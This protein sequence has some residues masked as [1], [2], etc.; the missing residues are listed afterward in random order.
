VIQQALQRQEM[1]KARQPTMSRR[2]PL[3]NLPC[4]SINLAACNLTYTRLL[5]GKRCTRHNVGSGV[6]NPLTG[7]TCANKSTVDRARP[8]Y[9]ILL[10]TRQRLSSAWN[11]QG[12][13]VARTACFKH[14]MRRAACTRHINNNISFGTAQKRC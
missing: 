1:M 9:R 7:A 11:R 6:G 12:M 14:S 3:K 5:G 10:E 4:R 8:V 2:R 13:G